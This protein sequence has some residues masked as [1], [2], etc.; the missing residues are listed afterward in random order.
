[1]ALPAGTRLGP[2]EILAPLGAGGMGEVYRARDPR[3]ERD[4]A[5]KV[6]PPNRMADEGRR[7]RF[8]QEA[9]AASAL[10]HPNI[11][12][13][14][15]IESDGG[16]DFI[17]MELV[18]GETLGGCLRRGR[19]SLRETLPIA[20]QLAD[21][22][23]RAHAAGIVHRDLK[24]SNVMVSP[25]GLVKVLDLGLAKLVTPED[26]D[27]RAE[28]LSADSA[29]GALTT[30]GRVTGTAG[31][32]SPEQATGGHVD[33]RSDVFSCGAVLYE[34]ATGCRAFT[35]P[36]WADTLSAVIREEPKP[37]RE[38]VPA[39]PR[40]LERLIERCLRK[41]P[42][43]RYQSMVDVKLVLEQI[44]QDSQADP[45]RSPQAPWPGRR[46]RWLVAAALAILLAL[47]GGWLLL[48]TR[49]APLP[50]PRVVPVTA[51][52]GE[53]RWP[54]FSPDGEQLAYSWDGE[55][56]DNED[57]YLTM[58]GSSVVRR[59][60]SCPE[61][62]EAP[63]WSPDGRQIAFVRHP[64]TGPGTIHLVSPLGGSAR[65]LSDFPTRSSLSWSPDGR[66][67][68][69]VRAPTSSEPDPDAG[70]IHLISVSG[71]EP[72]R[73]TRARPSG[74]DRNPAFSPDG[75]R[76]AFAS[77]A[78]AA[79]W[80]C[81][82]HVL[83]LD[84]DLVP[85]PPPRTVARPG[86]TAG[87]LGWMRDGAS[88]IYRVEEG[89]FLQY[90]W[91]VD[92]AGRRPPE[93]IEIAGARVIDVAVA[94]SRDRLAFARHRS[95]FDICRFAPGHDPEVVLGSSF[96][97]GAADF[98]PDGRRIAFESARSAERME[99]WLASADG[100][101]VEQLTRGPGRWQ[102]SPRWSP[103]ARSI[104]FD[105]RGEDGHWDIWTIAAEGGPPHRLTWHPGSE[106]QP[107]WSRDGRWI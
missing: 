28:T 33:A 32:M 15:E 104:A 9:R 106:N 90:L 89:P 59:L 58:I 6:L 85:R 98:S 74:D 96:Y 46:R 61:A 5:I 48:R 100:S 80:W 13:I 11:V 45:A 55:E 105:S 12:T 83:D 25:D 62:D 91:R 23:S 34:M 68:A 95:D 22:L 27:T 70:G 2:F 31:Y 82:I 57:I 102:G 1:M 65:K 26:S 66:W 41:E 64:A 39:L 35:G 54:S 84:A 93:R 103:D 37:P 87:G 43:R 3:L 94:P 99:I 38:L 56:G 16:A 29:D 36:S 88:V 18:E 60:T 44:E 81:E 72:R 52:R 4:V 20:R 79:P 53:E 8:V 14:H 86:R 75:R 24:T 30:T 49:E 92:A 101:H 51:S 97:E 10:N 7:R 77:C 21:A 67:L 63:N 40:E 69:A 107:N 76:L 17:V 71:G 19:L 42:G 50:P 47:A 73:L 78:G